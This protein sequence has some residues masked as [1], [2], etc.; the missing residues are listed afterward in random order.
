MADEVDLMILPE[1]VH[2]AL[3]GVAIVL[4]FLSIAEGR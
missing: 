2:F 1:H 3:T 4:L